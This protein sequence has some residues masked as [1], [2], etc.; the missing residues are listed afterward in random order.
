MRRIKLILAVTATMVM[1]L[2]MNAGPALADGGNDRWDDWHMNRDDCSW[3]DH[4]D[5]DWWCGH[6]DN[7]N[8]FNNFN[9]DCEWRFEEGW[10]LGPWGWQWGAWLLDC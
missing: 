5:C 4:N 2:A 10:F 8:H 6:N 3:C 9:N 7:F 1:M